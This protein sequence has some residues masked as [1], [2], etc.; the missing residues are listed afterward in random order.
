VSVTSLLV[1]ALVY[2]A[3]T[4]GA[5]FAL[6]TVRVLWLAPQV[7][8]RTAELVE[9]PFMLVVSYFAARWVVRRFRVPPA[10]AARALVGLIALA[11][12]LAV[13]FT[14]VLWLRG[15]TVGE[16]IASRDPVSGA[17]YGLSLVLFASMPLLVRTPV[18]SSASGG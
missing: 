6:G 15:L 5:G 10:A 16:W 1:P 8:A 4:F 3:L 14:V 11:C 9:T 18:T 2:F 12:L 13:E 7:G 17:V